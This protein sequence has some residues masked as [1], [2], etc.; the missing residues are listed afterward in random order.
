MNLG[1]F[2]AVELDGDL[3]EVGSLLLL[4]AAGVSGLQVHLRLPLL[5]EPLA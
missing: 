5:A 1:G 4:V 3:P 2:E